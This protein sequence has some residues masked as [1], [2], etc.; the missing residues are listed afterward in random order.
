MATAVT[1][2]KD[3][4]EVLR[5]RVRVAHMLGEKLVVIVTE[6]LS[7]EQ[8]E[9][10]EKLVETLSKHLHIELVYTEGDVVE[11]IL[12]VCNAHNIE[13]LISAAEAKEGLLRY[14][15]GSITRRLLKKATCSV[16]L[17]KDARKLKH[18]CKRVVIDGVNHPKTTNTLARGLSIA[19]HLLA[20]D[21][22][23]INEINLSKPSAKNQDEAQLINNE[24]TRLEKL[25]AAVAYRPGIT[26]NAK[27]LFGKRGYT[28]S[29][30]IQTTCVDLLVLNSPDTKLGYLDRVFTKD[31]E[32]ILS[33]MP[34]DLLIVHSH[35][36]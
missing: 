28:L 4:E 34:S 29:N 9:Q 36:S 22:E 11:S 23:I 10:L 31:F 30:Y 19:E 2:S 25:R 15:M 27:V 3:M 14:Y 12:Q 32:Y 1:I 17:M 35:K 21:C 18:E 6:A 24:Q 5:E 16:L 7:A 20:T 26:V 8:Q 33:E 13:L